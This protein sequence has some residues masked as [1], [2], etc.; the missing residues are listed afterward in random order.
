MKSSQGPFQDMIFQENALSLNQRLLPQVQKTN[1]N[2]FLTQNSNF[3]TTPINKNSSEQ[4]KYENDTQKQQNETEVENNY[5]TPTSSD[6]QVGYLQTN[7]KQEQTLPIPFIPQG[8]GFQPGTFPPYISSPMIIQT[9]TQ[10]QQYQSSQQN[11][12]IKDNYQYSTPNSQT[13]PPSQNQIQTTNQPFLPQITKPTNTSTHIQPQQP[14]FC[15]IQLSL[16]VQQNPSTLPK[17][18]TFNFRIRWTKQEDEQLLNLVRRWGARRWNEI[19]AS[20]GTKTAKQ[21]RDHYANCL[22]PG[23]RNSLWTVEEE[24]ILLSKYNEIGPHWSRIRT[25]FPGRTNAMIKNYTIMLLKRNGKE[26]SLDLQN[27]K[28]KSESESSCNSGSENE[29][30]D[31]PGLSKDKEKSDQNGQKKFSVNDINFL[32]NRPAKFPGPE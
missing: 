29:D 21:C 24:E 16:L 15:P 18:N 23:I 25:F 8:P 1:P 4:V 5:Y 6:S 22:D 3:S 28:D 31:D 20:L 9:P 14:S 26:I 13:F 7:I 32:L 11:Q 2:D 30:N 12:N 17:F 27:Q 10:V 19:A